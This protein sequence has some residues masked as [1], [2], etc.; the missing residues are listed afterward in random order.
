MKYYVIVSNEV[1]LSTDDLTEAMQA[2]IK[3]RFEGHEAI[4]ARYMNAA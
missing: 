3:Y 4:L 1:M 2:Y